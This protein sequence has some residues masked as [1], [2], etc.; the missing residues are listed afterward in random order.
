MLSHHPQSRRLLPAVRRSRSRF[1]E[2]SWAGNLRRRIAATRWPTK[3]LVRRAVQGVCAAC[4]TIQ[5]LAPL[6]DGR[7]RLVPGG[8]KLRGAP[9]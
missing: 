4:D 6:L 2:E 5:A 1:P 8:A 9:H 7:L 3:E